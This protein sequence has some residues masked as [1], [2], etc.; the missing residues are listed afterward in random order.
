MLRT[1]TFLP[2]CNDILDGYPVLD[3]EPNL[4][5]HLLQVLLQAVVLAH[6]ATQLA[7]GSRHRQL[8]LRVG[9]PTTNSRNIRLLQQQLVLLRQ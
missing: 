6:E 4:L 3:E 9:H 7:P 8:L 5:V 2:V 1:L